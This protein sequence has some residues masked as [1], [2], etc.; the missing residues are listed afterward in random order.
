M[1]AEKDVL[2]PMAAMAM[3]MRYVDPVL[4]MVLVATFHAAGSRRPKANPLS[5]MEKSPM[6]RRPAMATK[7]TTKSGT[8]LPMPAMENF[9]PVVHAAVRPAH[10]CGSTTKTRER[11]REV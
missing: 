11:E 4:L 5:A 3:P 6:E 8:C 1:R 9:C 7:P 2:R 10:A